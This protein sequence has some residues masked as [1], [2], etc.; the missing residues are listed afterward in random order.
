M[1]KNNP[2]QKALEAL[3]EKQ[4]EAVNKLDGP[5]IL[6]AGPGTGKTHVLAARVGQI[7]K[8]TD[9]GAEHIL[10]L[11]YT[12]AGA[13]AMRSRLLEWIGPEAHKITISTFHSFCNSVIQEH[14]TLFG[15]YDLQPITDLERI[16]IIRAVIDGLEK[17]HLL[18]KNNLFRYVNEKGLYSLFKLMKQEG[19]SYNYLNTYVIEYLKG[20][21]DNPDFKY[22]RKTGA[23][24]KGDPKVDKIEKEQR[25]MERLLALASCYNPYIEQLKEARRYDYD[26]MILWVLNAFQENKDLLSSYQEKFLYFLVD[27]Y[28]DTNGAQEKLLQLLTGYWEQPNLFVVGDDDQAIYEFQGA[29]LDNLIDLYKRFEGEIDILA[30]KNNYRSNQEILDASFKL[31]EHNKE[32]AVN[33]IDEVDLDKQLESSLPDRRGDKNALLVHEYPNPVHEDIGVFEQIKNLI[34]KGV[35]ASEIA[36]IYTQHKYGESLRMLFQQEQIPY[37]SKRKI[38]VLHEPNIIQIRTEL[39]FFEELLNSPKK[40]YEMLPQVL[41][42]PHWGVHMDDIRILIELNNT[43]IEEYGYAAFVKLKSYLKS[44]ED[45]FS[46]PDLLQNAFDRIEQIESVL[47]EGHLLRFVMRFFQH[48][49]WV[50]YI[51]DGQESQWDFN[52]LNSFWSYVKENIEGNPSLD[53]GG[54]LETLDELDSN[55]LSIDYIKV[56]YAEN[57]VNLLTA[58]GAKGLEFS[59][60][61]L[62]NCVSDAWEKSR[63]AAGLFTLPPGLYQN[64]MNINLQRQSDEDYRT[65]SKRR[66]FYVAMTRAKEKLI[67][68]YSIKN[69]KDKNQTLSRFL[70]ELIS[71]QDLSTDK[72]VASKSSINEFV[73]RDMLGLDQS[74]SKVFD[75]NWVQ[76]RLEEFKLSSSSLRSYLECKRTFFFENILGLTAIPNVHTVFGQVAHET[77]NRLIN[78]LSSKETTIS[79]DQIQGIFEKVAERSRYLLTENSYDDLLAKG[80]ELLPRFWEHTSLGLNEKSRAELPVKAFLDKTIPLVGKLDRLDYLDNKHIRIVDYKSSRKTAKLQP[81]KAD[82]YGGIYWFQMLFYQVLAE[83]SDY[84]KFSAL[85]LQVQYLEDKN[86][87]SATGFDADILRFTPEETEWMRQLIRDS[88]TSILNDDFT[89]KCDNAS[90]KWCG[91]KMETM[92]ESNIFESEFKDSFDES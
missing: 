34:D 71:D 62:I 24:S 63:Q 6:L 41:V 49:N 57:G 20:L 85:E 40:A 53:L 81:A 12:D 56:E 29:K 87:G 9:T 89:S 28:Q 17:N 77:L 19:W 45:V 47:R 46:R 64:S 42:H 66:L 75:S 61:F 14:A 73:L 51:L 10:C 11:T 55:G 58:H 22:K 74:L 4:R 60:V 44:R 8:S 79:P 88:Y 72:K 35:E 86:S 48:S 32:R 91:F 7:L 13:Y 80:M 2:F 90:C 38:N 31:I 70:S 3:N 36:V 21:P 23:H 69:L 50:N 18:R 27:E 52:V 59:Y 25:K 65:E 1:S 43:F 16:K 67:C 26:D 54:L 68:S 76:K 33:L 92:E 82:N 15:H 37:Q 78:Q 5:M 83:E 39:V 84:L 30:L